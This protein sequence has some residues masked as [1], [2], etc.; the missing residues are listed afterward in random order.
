MGIA[1]R[2]RTRGAEL[3]PATPAQNAAPT[4]FSR[5]FNLVGQSTWWFYTTVWPKVDVRT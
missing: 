1:R 4:W 3:N 5:Y 2:P